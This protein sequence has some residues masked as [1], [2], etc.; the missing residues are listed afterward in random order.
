MPDP[1][2]EAVEGAGQVSAYRGIAY[3]VF[4][5][6]SM[7]QFGNRIPQF[8]FEVMRPAQD[9]DEGDMAQAVTAVSLIPGTG[10]ICA[11]HNAGALYIG[12]W[13]Q[14]QRQYEHAIGQE[15]LCNLDRGAG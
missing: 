12:F 14:S 2:I 15:R 7:G 5:D 13:G 11:G 9:P 8:T 10:R 1:K 3:V 4:E 6:L